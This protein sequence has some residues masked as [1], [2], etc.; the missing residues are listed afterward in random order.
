M[1]VYRRRLV[2]FALALSLLCMLIP[3]GIGLICYFNRHEKQA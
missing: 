1:T 2:C 3:A